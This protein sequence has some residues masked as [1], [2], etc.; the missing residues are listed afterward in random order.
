MKTRKPIPSRQTP[1]FTGPAAPESASVPDC[2]SP[3]FMAFVESQIGEILKGR[4]PDFIN[5]NPNPSRRT[6]A[7]TAIAA[8]DSSARL[9]GYRAAFIAIQ[10]MMEEA[11]FRRPK[12]MGGREHLAAYREGY[13]IGLLFAHC[14]SAFGEFPEHNVTAIKVILSQHA[15]QSAVGSDELSK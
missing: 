10:N 5:S 8:P 13:Y 9:D 6:P 3:A 2:P 4:T 1:A 7:F 12:K 15:S 11:Y 14:Q